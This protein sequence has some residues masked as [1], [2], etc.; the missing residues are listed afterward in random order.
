VD[1]ELEDL[2]LPGV[3]LTEKCE[4]KKEFLYELS[5]PETKLTGKI[6]T[7]TSGR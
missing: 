4:C 1:S 2:N 5:I 3:D 7:T 6:S